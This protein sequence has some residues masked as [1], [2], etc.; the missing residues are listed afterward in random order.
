MRP[1]LWLTAPPK[2]FRSVNIEDIERA[3]WA[4]TIIMIRR[5]KEAMEAC[6]KGELKEYI[7]TKKNQSS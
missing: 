6:S 5:N 3:S 7:G 1:L 2:I 4:T